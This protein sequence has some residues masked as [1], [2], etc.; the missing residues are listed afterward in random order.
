M[1]IQAAKP[2]SPVWRCQHQKWNIYWSPVALGSGEEGKAE[3][4]H[5][6]EEAYFKEVMGGYCEK[7]NR[8]NKIMLNKKKF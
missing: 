5:T 2:L 4:S 1:I 7:I 8:N 3:K 6:D